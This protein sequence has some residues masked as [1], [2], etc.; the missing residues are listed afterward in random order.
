MIR[1][2]G[3]RYELR[4]ETPSISFAPDPSRP[5]RPTHE[6]EYHANAARR[7]KEILAPLKGA[8]DDAIEAFLPEHPGV[9]LLPFD[10]GLP[11]VH[12]RDRQASGPCRFSGHVGSPPDLNVGFDHGTLSLAFAKLPEG[13]A[14]ERLFGAI[15]GAIWTILREHHLRQR[16]A[17]RRGPVPSEPARFHYTRAA[18][19]TIE[20][21]NGE[22]P[23][24]PLAAERL[25]APAALELCGSIASII[26]AAES[27]GV[28]HA[29]LEASDIRIDGAEV[30]IDGFGEASSSKEAHPPEG[31]SNLFVPPGPR[32]D[33]TARQRYSL[34]HVIFQVLAGRVLDVPRAEA[35]DHDLAV[36]RALAEI[37]PIAVRDLLSKLLAWTPARRPS[38]RE[39]RAVLAAVVEPAPPERRAP[40]KIPA[41]LA[42]DTR[43]I[44]DRCRKCGRPAL[45]HA[46]RNVGT[47]NHYGPDCCW[48]ERERRML[49]VGGAILLAA[50]AAL[51]AWWVR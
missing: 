43:G 12:D 32:V 26:A 49:R 2:Q 6:Q 14:L 4:L 3:R 50:L 7:F 17:G 27:D 40:S 42:A 9:A 20:D 33:W 21:L 29:D 16:E 25:A 30:S 45:R 15:A 10:G 51:I 5:D 24:R 44:L 28:V 39:A 37:E 48:W 22:A 46:G 18:D 8:L 35:T 23:G 38:A 31:N 19:G 11:L 13:G 36:A 41:R 1:Q 34:G 47:A